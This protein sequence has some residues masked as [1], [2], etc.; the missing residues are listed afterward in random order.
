MSLGRTL[1]GALLGLAAGAIAVG[2][3]YTPLLETWERRTLDLRTRAFADA[4]RADPRIVAVVIDQRSLDAVAAPRAEAAASRAGRGR[5]TTTPRSSTTCPPRAPAPSRFDMIFSEREHLHAP[6]PRRRRPPLA[7]ATAS[8]PVVQS[9]MLTRE[10]LDGPGP[11]R[12]PR[13]AAA[14]PAATR[15]CAADAPEAARSTRPRC[16]SNRCSAA[17]AALGWIGFE[18]DDDGTCR[19]VRPT[20]VYAPAGQPGRVEIW[21]FPFALAALIGRARRRAGGPP[22]AA[23]TCASTASACRSTRTAACSCASTAARAPTASSPS[24]PCWTPRLRAEASQS[25]EAA[26]R[27]LPRQGRPHRRHRGG[28]PRPALHLD[29]A[30]CC[31]AT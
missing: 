18:P 16:R 7:A 13:V 6:G 5:A 9:V 23:R 2:A 17:R 22:R 25:T 30:R 29:A 28:T 15:A 3:A 10:A 12:R 24:P 26:A 20:A 27:G 31:P 14:A 21:S 19:S 1:T 8:R 11:A 4:S